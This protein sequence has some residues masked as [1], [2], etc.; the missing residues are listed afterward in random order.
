MPRHIARVT[1]IGEYIRHSSCQRRFKLGHNNQ[2]LYKSLPFSD[3]P[4]HVIDV[5]LT[6]AGRKREEEWSN[7]LEDMGLLPL[8]SAESRHDPVLWDEFVRRLTDVPEGEEAFAREVEVRGIVGAFSLIGRI[9]FVVLRW[10]EDG[11]PYLRLVECKASRRDRVY[12]RIQVTLYRMMVRDLLTATPITVGAHTIGPDDIECVVARIDEA[13]NRV[14]PILDV[15]S[16]PMID[17]LTADAERLLAVS[18]HLDR[19]LGT[20]LDTLP[21]QLDAKCDDCLFSVHC[22]SE[23]ARLRRLELLGLRPTTCRALRG[24]GLPTLDDLAELD[25]DDP[26]SERIR[27]DPRL[28][29]SLEQ[30]QTRAE[31]RQATLPGDPDGTFHVR[32]LPYAGKGQLPEHTINDVPLVRIYL[33]VSYDYV[34]NRVNG[35]AAHLTRSPAQLETPFAENED[36]NLR[37]SPDLREKQRAFDAQTQKQTTL[38][39]RDLTGHAIELCRF[40]TIPW[41]GRY[42][43]DNGAEMQLLQGFLRELVDAIAEIADADEAPI[44]FYLWSRSEMKHLLE[45][46]SRVGAG[47]MRHL[48]EL[49]GC[50]E[51]LEQLIYSCLQD[52]VGSRFAL[53]WTSRG[54]V[55]ATALRWFGK[56]YHWVRRVGHRGQ[57][58][59]L[60]RAF[61]RDVFDFRTTLHATPDGQWCKDK[62][63][64][65][66]TAHRYEIRSRNFDGLTAPYWRAY[67]GTLPTDSDYPDRPDVRSALKD[68]RA[69][70]RPGLLPA[71]LTA[72]AQAIR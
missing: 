33:T 56:R 5:V 9:D 35:L 49:L 58:V 2:A 15:E 43:L 17:T 1:D 30:L 71:F 51:S 45:A 38:I 54:L 14:Q 41:S 3:R 18:G 32:S 59:D 37:P 27:N 65:G 50:R 66:A 16:F 34:E 13:T 48:K 46:C 19:I 53:G 31:T 8:Q 29:E 69:A 44:H 62:T 6:E 68:Y 63:T 40:Q 61:S 11:T 70:Q 47:L 23:S 22:F 72:R 21:Y 4:F 25:P 55:V 42:E 60:E 39:D 12:H 57:S 52:E 20:D 36:G 28:T 26:S 67:W 7:A 64:P 24:L 10:R